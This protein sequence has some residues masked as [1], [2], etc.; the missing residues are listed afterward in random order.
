MDAFLKSY[1][2]I[3]FK[4]IELEKDV[5]EKVNL[6]Y[7]EPELREQEWAIDLAKAKNLPTLD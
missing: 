3:D 4:D 7:I 2:D 5:F 1:P 6:D